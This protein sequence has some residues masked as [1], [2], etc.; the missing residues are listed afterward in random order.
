MALS[1]EAELQTAELRIGIRRCYVCG[2]T[3]HL[4]PGC[5]LRKQRHTPPSRGSASE[6]KSGSWRGNAKTQ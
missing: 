3:Q 2:S 5:P 6:P 4:R 1:E